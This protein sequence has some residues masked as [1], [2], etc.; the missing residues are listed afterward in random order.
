MEEIEKEI[1]SI[2]QGIQELKK[3]MEKSYVLIK[4]YI[5][6]ICEASRNKEYLSQNDFERT[7]DILLDYGFHVNIE[8][9]FELMRSTYITIYP[10]SVNQ[11]IE[12]YKEQFFEENE[13]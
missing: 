3:E 7:L 10:D 12:F 8:E 6:N 4:E 9:E 5:L 11:Y 2:K 13:E 1:E